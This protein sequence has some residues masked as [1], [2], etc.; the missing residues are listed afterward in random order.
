M[1]IQIQGTQMD[2][3]PAIKEYIEEKIGG[4]SKFVERYEAE[5][6]IIAKVDIGRTTHHHSKGD[7]YYA[8]V[9]IALPGGVVRAENTHEDLHAAVDSVKGTLKKELVKYKEKDLS[10]R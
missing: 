3:T 4:L 9:T 8:E 10:T 2:L 5:T 1:Q 6:N 7:V